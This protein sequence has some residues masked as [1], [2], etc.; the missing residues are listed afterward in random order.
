MNWSKEQPPKDELKAKYHSGMTTF[1]LA[2]VYGTDHVS[3]YG[4]LVKYGI[5]RAKTAVRFDPGEHELE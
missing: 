3:I 5:E 2:D 4:W 1:E